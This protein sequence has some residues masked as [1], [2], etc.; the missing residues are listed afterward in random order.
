MLECAATK[1]E[2]D[3][4][5]MAVLAETRVEPALVEKLVLNSDSSL[6]PQNNQQPGLNDVRLEGETPSVK[7]EA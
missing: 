5:E 1:T 4:P 6:P 7:L 2:N 3:V